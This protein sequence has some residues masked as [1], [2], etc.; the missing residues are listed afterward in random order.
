MKKAAC[1]LAS[2]I[3]LSALAT[4]ADAQSVADFYR[5]KQIRVI[6][7]T[8]PGDYDTWVRFVVRHMRQ[9]MP[10]N[11][12]FV[13]ENMPGAGS[14]IAA[15]HLYNKAAQ[16]GT[17]LGS[18]SRNIP[19]F[20]FTKKPNV[21]FDPLKY[22]WIGSPEMT[23]RGCFAR[24]DSGVKVVEDLYE[25]ELLV[26]TDGAGT[27]L[28][29]MP[30]LLK[31]LLGMKFKT[32]DGYQGSNGVVL[33]MARNEVAGIC[34]TVTAFAQSAQNMLDDGTVRLLFTTER[35]RV[36]RLKVPTIF[37][38][39][40]TEEQRDILAFHASS[41]ETGRPWLSPPGVPPDRVNALRRA[42][43]ATMKDQA[44]LDEAKQRNLEVDPRTGE[45]IEAVLRSIASLP[46]DLTAKAGEMIRK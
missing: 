4:S 25:R 21:F 5:G 9:Y 24:P 17:V 8:A 34:Q 2:V 26:G 46:E 3:I 36:P 11:P 31:N 30:V 20:A 35:E 40:K 23:N 37:E 12:G 38:F 19:N 1:A 10:G 29:E 15:N 16:D 44:F 33:A 45:Q 42:F 7:G 41:L 39:A 43:D 22:N 28:S 6:V 27:S 32:I 14:L 13:V 18:L